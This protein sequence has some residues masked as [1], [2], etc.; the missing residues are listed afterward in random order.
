[1]T[2]RT[3]HIV[4]LGNALVDVVAAVEPEVIGR[5]GLTSGGMHLVDAEA[6]HALFDEVG[7]GV[8]QSG[9]SVANSIAHLADLGVQGTYLGKIAGDD[10]G[11]TFREG[12]V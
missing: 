4:G 2:D 1:M 7:P 5:H 8:R 11:A 12:P 10:L 9:G 3:P 6:A